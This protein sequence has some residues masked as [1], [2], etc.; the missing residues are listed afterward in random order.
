[1]TFEEFQT[2]CNQAVSTN[3]PVVSPCPVVVGIETDPIESQIGDTPA[4]QIIIFRMKPDTSTLLAIYRSVSFTFDAPNNQ[5]VIRPLT[6][7]T[8]T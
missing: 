5:T 3:Q 2:L 6:T 1:M 4:H 8:G 7:G